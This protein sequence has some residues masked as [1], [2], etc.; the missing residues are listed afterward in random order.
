MEEI[1]FFEVYKKWYCEEML[2]TYFIE[3]AN[4]KMGIQKPLFSW[5]QIRSRH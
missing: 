4:K 5:R 2:S 3:K 1:S